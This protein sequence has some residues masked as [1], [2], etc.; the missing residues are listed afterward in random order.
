M[1][2]KNL[3]RDLALTKE[4]IHDHENGYFSQK[5]KKK[6]KKNLIMEILS[7]I[8]HLYYFIIILSIHNEISRFLVL[9]K[10]LPTFHAICFYRKS[11][12]KMFLTRTFSFVNRFSNFFAAYFAT[13]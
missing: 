5:K 3:N 10:Y 12:F 7:W 11:P 4:I 8:S 9:K 2:T 1:L 13:Y 6:K